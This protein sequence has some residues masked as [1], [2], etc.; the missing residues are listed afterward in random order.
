MDALED[1]NH[2]VASR[3]IFEVL[4]DAKPVYDPCNLRVRFRR[5]RIFSEFSEKEVYILGSDFSG[6]EYS[7]GLL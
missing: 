4:A 7:A 5:L 3:R 6:S 2:P 1:E